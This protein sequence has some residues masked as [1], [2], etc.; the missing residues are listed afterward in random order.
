MTD[1]RT[2]M[3][4]AGAQ[5][6]AGK[7]I[8]STHYLPQ[9]PAWSER[10]D[11]I[12]RK[13]HTPAGLLVRVLRSAPDYDAVVVNGTVG[14]ASFYV[15]L[16]AAAV[17][18]RRRRGPAVVITGCHWKSGT[19]RLN[20]VLRRAGIAVVDSA[21]VTYC[22]LAEDERDML[23][24]LWRLPTDRI[25]LTPYMYNLTDDELAASVSNNG[26][27]FSGGDSMRDYSTLIEAARRVNA[28]FVLA[29]RSITAGSSP[30]PSNLTFGPVSHQEFVARMRA[31]SVVVVSML[32]GMERTAGQQTFLNAM[33]LG[34][35]VVVTDSPGVRDYIDEGETGYIVP[36][37]DVTAMT[38]RLEWMLQ[39]ANQDEI[40]HVAA[41]GR[42]V[43]LSR[44]GP[45]EHVAAILR[46]VGAAVSNNRRRRDAT[47]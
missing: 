43:A 25:A 17:V 1:A 47:A 29:T 11:M 21:Q 9:R 4:P 42:E 18:A 35:P 28:P 19:S 3:Q 36:P 41:K 46:V 7:R 44:F 8:L 23:S 38:K 26:S 12:D 6:A 5:D 39:P 33:A 45:N 34:K 10:V 20:R 32:P 31:A 40:H 2:S 27:I 22:V 14:A 24:R 13:R 15:D 30:M 37:G 16:I